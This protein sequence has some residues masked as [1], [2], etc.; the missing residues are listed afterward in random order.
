[1]EICKDK[2]VLDDDVK[3]DIELIIIMCDAYNEDCKGI[4]NI[5]EDD[6]NEIIESGLDALRRRFRSLWW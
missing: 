1:M 3:K 2:I 5:N 4:S 6:I